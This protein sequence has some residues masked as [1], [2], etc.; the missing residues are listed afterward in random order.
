[1]MNKAVLILL[2][3]LPACANGQYEEAIDDVWHQ[4]KLRGVAFR[5]VGQEPAWVLEIINNEEILLVMDY[6]QSKIHFSYEEPI[7]NKQQRKTRFE[8]KEP[9][10]LEILI[11]GEAC[12]DVMSGEKFSTSVLISLKDKL[13]KG[14]GRA[15]Y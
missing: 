3:I 6:G 7:E 10:K 11:S 13:L 4:A 14:C 1:M 12:Q 5:A 15:L 8:L 2:T 9:A